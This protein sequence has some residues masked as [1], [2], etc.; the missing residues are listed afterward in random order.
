MEPIHG[1][2]LP[3]VNERRRRTCSI[4]AVPMLENQGRFLLKVSDTGGTRLLKLNET[5][6]RL[7]DRCLTSLPSAQDQ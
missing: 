5:L 3:A 4:S 6:L 1:I 2:F 7:M